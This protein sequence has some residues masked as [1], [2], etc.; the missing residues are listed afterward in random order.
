MDYYRNVVLE[1]IKKDIKPEMNIIL[2]I[3]PNG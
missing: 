3:L 1:I 2:S